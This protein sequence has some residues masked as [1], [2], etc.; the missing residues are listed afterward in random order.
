MQMYWF[1]LKTSDS[2]TFHSQLREHAAR[3]CQRHERRPHLERLECSPNP[4]MTQVS[5]SLLNESIMR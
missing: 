2:D 4:V 5:Q 3:L 1:V